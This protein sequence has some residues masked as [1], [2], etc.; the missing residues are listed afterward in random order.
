MNV[1]SA[2]NI[3]PE[4][5]PAQH[6]SDYNSASFTKR[7]LTINISPSD[8]NLTDD[9]KKVLDGAYSWWIEESLKL[10]E[11]SYGFESKFGN[12][13][14]S[15]ELANIAGAK[16]WGSAG[17]NGFSI[18]LSYTTFSGDN[19][20]LDGNGVDKCITI[21]RQRRSFVPISRRKPLWNR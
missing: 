4:T 5:L 1:K 10:I 14:I 17:F 19:D 13:P 20:D 11:E 3:I 15:F 21:S 2:E 18:N 16:W 8:Y 6:L 7:N 9:G 12:K